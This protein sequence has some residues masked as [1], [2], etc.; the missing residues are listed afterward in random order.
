ME[1]HSPMYEKIK[2]Y[3]EHDLWT[4]AQVRKAVKCRRITQ[5]ECDE[6]LNG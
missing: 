4:A 2:Y 1:E 5:E 6:I 3:Y